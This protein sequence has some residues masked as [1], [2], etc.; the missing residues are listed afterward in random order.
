MFCNNCGF[1][2]SDDAKFCTNCGTKIESKV[3]KAE[4]PVA[5][6]VAEE[7]V[8]PVSNE[9][10]VLTE[11]IREPATEMP[12]NTTTEQPAEARNITETEPVVPAPKKKKSKKG[13]W[14]GFGV[15]SVILAALATVVAL[16]FSTVKN[17]VKKT[18][19]SD[20]EYFKYVHE[21]KAEDLAANISQAISGITDMAKTPED[22]MAKLTSAGADLTF[23]VNKPVFDL[24]ADVA[25]KNGAKLDWIS[26]ASAVTGVVIDDESKMKFDIGVNLNDTELIT[27]NAIMDIQG[28]KIY[29]AIPDLNEEYVYIDMNSI[30]AQSQPA[31]KPSGNVSLLSTSATPTMM[32]VNPY[33]TLNGI[34][35]EVYTKHLPEQKELEALLTKYINLILSCVEN[36]ASGNDTLEIG[37]L[38][39]KCSKY[40]V[41][42]DDELVQKIFKAVLTELRDDATVKQYVIGTA[43]ELGED[44]EDVYDEFRDGIKDAL[45]NLDELTVDDFEYSIWVDAS[46]NTVA[47]TVEIDSFI[48]E[49]KSFEK[50]AKF[51]TE[52]S[53]G[54]KDEMI[55]FVN[56]GTKEN[57]KVNSETLFKMNDTTYVK[58]ETSRNESENGDFIGTLT[59]SLGQGFK[60]MMKVSGNEILN[61]FADATI[62]IECNAS[63][64]NADAKLALVLN[65]EE[66]CSIETG[67]GVSDAGKIEIPANCIDGSKEATM[68]NWAKKLDFEKLLGKLESAN[69]PSE[70]VS[71]LRR[72]INQMRN[73]GI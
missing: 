34:D 9:T 37:G 54:E 4:E 49:Y 43:N 18:V 27:A 10:V 11:N 60:D 46:G 38:T 24:I 72:N 29:F 32:T 71:E 41:D 64:N 14:I 73:N 19:S 50:G 69:V 20:E 28:G 16:N 70:L 8:A 55:G 51:A 26:N 25:A 57:G 61:K 6:P 48:F 63:G 3:V 58:V 30:Y 13:L 7:V 2:L 65:S 21:E 1:R 5:A 31:Q 47:F 17:F 36:V 40:T 44:G 53:M 12:A 68:E 66:W 23:K 45:S 67:L 33:A 22:V 56:E 39:C 59:I 52:I 15:A 62:V 42:V 35:I